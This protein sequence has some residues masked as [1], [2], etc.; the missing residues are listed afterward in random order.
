MARV[1]RHAVSPSPP[2]QSAPRLPGKEVRAE[3]LRGGLV[4]W[5]MPSLRVVGDNFQLALRTFWGHRLRSALTL[6]GI[7]IGVTTVVS[8]MALL[9]GL[10]RKIDDDLR[11]LGANG[12]QLQ[13]YPFGFNDADPGRR[14]NITIADYDAIR[15]HVP[16]TAKVTAEA[17]EFAKKLSTD[18]R[19]TQPSVAVA[20]GT[21]DFFD[22]NA[23]DVV[24][25]RTFSEAEVEEGRPVIVL[26]AD[27]AGALFP[28]ADPVGQM[29]R[30][31]GRRF[32]VIGVLARR[33]SSFGF[34]VDNQAMM[35]IPAFFELFGRNRSLHVSMQARSTDVLQ[36]AQ[37]GVQ[38]LMRQRHKLR[39]DQADDF[40]IFSNDSATAT[41]NQIA[42]V[43]TAAT[44]GVC[45][46]SLIVGGIG[47]LN[48]MLVSVT[49][50][51][52]EIGV[53]KALGAR[54]HRILGQFATEAVVLSLL[55]G[56]VG[57]GLG[58]SVAFLGR[59]ALGFPTAVPPWAVAL[60]LAMSS[61][62]GLVFGIYPASR[63]A[64]LDPVEAMRSE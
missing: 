25:G 32:Q 10:Q 48:I 58:F 21:L 43:V 61:G 41:F 37:D 39:A 2:E 4:R 55:G 15:K 34:S 27:V 44:F 5:L 64:N 12:F 18:A 28:N 62:V 17:W 14:P 59:W 11:G 49:E 40:Y 38:L 54:R 50:R 29:L 47:I 19:E 13:K 1:S 7:V 6:L 33:G 9:E 56:V 45:L 16:D 24:N 46:L 35:P 36:R 42:A 63:A 8:M 53:R 31:R 20:G 3:A 52:H 60:A 57:V 23:A 51:T 30:V 26:G 22:T